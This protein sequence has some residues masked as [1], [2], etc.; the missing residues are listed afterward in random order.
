MPWDGGIESRVAELTLSRTDGR[1]SP[2]VEPEAEFYS[3][4][5]TSPGPDIV[6]TD[7]LIALF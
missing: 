7:R 1:A 4:V 2:G 5:E 6:R 3:W